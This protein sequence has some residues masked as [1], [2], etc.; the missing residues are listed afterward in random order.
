MAINLTGKRN[1]REVFAYP[2]GDYDVGM[3]PIK[4][5][6]SFGGF[7]ND[8]GYAL[9]LGNGGNQNDHNPI[10]AMVNREA[11]RVYYN[12]N[13]I[14]PRSDMHKKVYMNMIATESDNNAWKTKNLN[15]FTNTEGASVKATND[16]KIVISGLDLKIPNTAKDVEDRYHKELERIRKITCDEKDAISYWVKAMTVISGAL[17]VILFIFIIIYGIYR[18]FF[19][20]CEDTL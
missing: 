4:G 18:I 10:E 11:N 17:L 9:D 5:P 16:G 7:D 20:T 8:Q 19:Y 14:N 1:S 15:T 12:E 2:D 3:K 13:K 6:P